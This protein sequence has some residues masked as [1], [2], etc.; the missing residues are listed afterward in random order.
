MTEPK[1]HAWTAAL[2]ISFSLVLQ[3]AFAAEML[4]PGWM[5]PVVALPA[6]ILLTWLWRRAEHQHAA[7]RADNEL[8][9]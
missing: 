2:V 9:I 1:S 5:S 6:L 3:V 8:V 7:A 4:G